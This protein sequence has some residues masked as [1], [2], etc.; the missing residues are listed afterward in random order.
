MREVQ[1]WKPEISHTLS[2][3]INNDYSCEQFSLTY[4]LAICPRHV[5]KGVDIFKHTVHCYI[6]FLTK[7]VICKNTATHQFS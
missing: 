5:Q 1:Q 4:I 7:I 2:S 6:Q 3:F